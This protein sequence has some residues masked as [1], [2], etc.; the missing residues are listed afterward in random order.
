MQQL[1]ARCLE[2][3]AAF[4]HRLLALDLEL[5]GSLRDA[6]IGG[7]LDRPEAGLR[8]LRQRPHAEVVAAAD[9]LAVEVVLT[10]ERQAQRV[11][12]ELPAL[13]RI[14]SN[15]CEAGYEENVH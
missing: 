3:G 13:R 8:R 9:L 1:V 4:G 5:D 2:L 11:E 10:R 6:D 15:D 12:V 14:R 7:P